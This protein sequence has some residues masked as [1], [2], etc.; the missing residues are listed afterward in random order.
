M[1]ERCRQFRR[2]ALRQVVAGDFA[3]A[4]PPTRACDRFLLCRSGRS[5][6]RSALAQRIDDDLI[7]GRLATNEET[8]TTRSEVN[9]FDALKWSTMTP[10][11]LMMTIDGDSL[12]SDG[13]FPARN[14]ESPSTSRRRGPPAEEQKMVS[15][16][17]SAIKSRQPIPGPRQ[18]SSTACGNPL[19][20]FVIN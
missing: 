19:A 5:R 7:S 1:F 13:G 12:P 14:I 18:Y 8:A 20:F 17:K 15:L 6:A 4:P 3:A 9:V 10:A 11:V 16:I 2:C